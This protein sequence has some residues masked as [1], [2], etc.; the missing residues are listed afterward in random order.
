MAYKN[1]SEEKNDESKSL[2]ED[3]RRALHI[4]FSLILVLAVL[5]GAMGSTASHASALAQS[6]TIVD[7]KL[8]S[9]LA[10]KL[11]GVT[12]L[13]PLEVVV[14][15]SDPSAAARVRGL[16]S[17]FFQMQT[18]PMA[19]AILTAGQVSDLANWPEVY[20]ITLNQPLKYFLHESISL[21]KAD[22][23]WSTYGETGSNATVAIIDSGIDATHPDLQY[24]SKVIQNVK[25][26]PYE[27]SR[28]NVQITDT[29]SGHGT[30]VAGTVGGTGA[31]S[32]GYYR[33]VAPGVRL[34]G[35]GAGEGLSI[36]TATQ[37]YDWVLTHHAQYD[38]RVVSNSW[39]STGGSINL[40]NPVVVAS[41][42]AY[43]RGIL[44]VFA[45]GNDGGYDVMNPYSIA[46][47][48]LSVAAGD[49]AAQ[50]AD[51]S[52]RGADGDYFKHP[53]ITAPGVAIY[54]TRTK[55]VGI[56]ALDP[57]PNPVNPLWTP[58]YTVM[59]GTSMATPHVSGAAALLLSHNPNLSPDEVMELLTSNATPM[60][61]YALHEA[62]YGYM[63]VLAAYQGS[64]DEAGNL[65]A[66]LSGSRLHNAEEVYGLDPNYPVS[67]DE[68]IYTGF[69]PAGATESNTGV[70]VTPIDHEVDLTNNSAILYVDVSLTW[71]PE[72]EDAFDMAVL[73]PDGVVLMTSG[74]GLAEGEQALFVPR[75][76][77]V[78][79]IRLYPFVTVAADYQLSVKTAYGTQPEN[80]PPHTTPAYDNY[81]GLDAIFKTYGVLGLGSAYFRGGDEGFIDFVLT[82][83]DGVPQAGQ[84]GNMQV[85]LTDRN[86]TTAFLEDT[87][88][89]Q[90]GGA[91]RISF[92]TASAD[93]K[94]VAGP[95]TFRLLWSGSETVKVPLIQ[96]F[97]NHL[98]IT[99][100]SGGTDY[101]SGETVTFTGSVAQLN[102]VTAA[103]VQ[104]TPVGGAPV[105]VS[106][107][108]ADG[109]RLTSTSVQTDLQG[110]FSGAIVAP[111]EARGKVM[112]VAESSFQD[113]T[114]V[115]GPAEWYGS[116]DVELTFPGNL[117][118]TADLR[119][120][121]QTDAGKKFQIHIQASGSDPDGAADISSI[122]LTLTDSKSRILK[123]WSLA[124][125]S[126]ADD[127]TW[128][129]ESAYRVSGKEPWTLTLTVTDRAGQSATESATIT[130]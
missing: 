46:P 28:E 36:L 84:A 94:G 50:L 35:L 90:G 122:T 62:G 110:N 107:V 34:V 101:Q 115:L 70:S 60:P 31:A 87:V 16:A 43:N 114:I 47:W 52:S 10:A 100:E 8:D 6:S 72:V 119:A 24:G 111:A 30:H 61:A 23:V 12:P 19:G 102:S 20:S 78:Y 86:G 64:L 21:I 93:W 75:K 51:F 73:D 55:T 96:F 116:G 7:Q 109:Q 105:T 65:Q 63:D 104:T 66:F 108:S 82:R 97:L 79:T 67:F 120:T 33:G 32:Q 123:R 39:G 25:V 2:E 92:D 99:L 130:K 42:E 48:V 13:T 89:D 80:W 117:P 27:L 128:L 26:L 40:R 9:A 37:A 68:R 18:L 91:Y 83:A 1:Q 14:V 49:K 113:P 129:F 22:Q 5:L 38:I 81:L 45:A 85:A 74:N 69:V 98:D 56:T 54:S 53:D 3:M 95:I 118:P 125:F 103:D 41:L 15:F 4:G 121:S 126:K 112:L 88:T 58:Y 59:D 127:L 17:R 77:G 106:L 29:S 71:T 57:L 44:S 124:D 11:A 76:P